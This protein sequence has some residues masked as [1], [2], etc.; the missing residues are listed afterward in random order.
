M[1]LGMSLSSS[2]GKLIYARTL[3]MLDL[4]N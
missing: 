2:Y 4:M 1:Q 3:L